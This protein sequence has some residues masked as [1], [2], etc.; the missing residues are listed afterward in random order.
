MRITS[1][2]EVG[3][4]GSIRLVVRPAAGCALGD[5]VAE[6]GTVSGNGGMYAHMNADEREQFIEALGGVGP[7]RL[8]ALHAA[9]DKITAERNRWRAEA[10]RLRD[11]VATVARTRGVEK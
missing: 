8:S 7:R 6:V 11:G 5:C 3:G 4:R 9:L 2:T 1:T 10:K